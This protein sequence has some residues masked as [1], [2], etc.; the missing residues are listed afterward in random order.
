MYMHANRLRETLIAITLK[1]AKIDK[2]HGSVPNIISLLGVPILF[3]S[4]T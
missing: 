1:G 3:L 4:T 2:K